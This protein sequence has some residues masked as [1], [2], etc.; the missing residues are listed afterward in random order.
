VEYETRKET[1]VSKNGLKTDSG[2]LS[3]NSVGELKFVANA[4]LFWSA[5]LFL[6]GN[7]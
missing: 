6:P 1:I 4:L 3:S 5:V 7:G 2:F